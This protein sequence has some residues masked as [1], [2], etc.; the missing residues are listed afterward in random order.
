MAFVRMYPT[1]D[2]LAHFEELGLPFEPADLTEKGSFSPK[3]TGVTFSRQPVGDSRRDWHRS[4]YRRY[5][6]FLTGTLEIEVGGGEERL[7]RFGSGDVLLVEDVTGKGHKSWVVGNEP[8]IS[9]SSD[10]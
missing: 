2:G 6:V 8:V 5:V 10:L 1:P 4:D 3:I 7:R 9:M